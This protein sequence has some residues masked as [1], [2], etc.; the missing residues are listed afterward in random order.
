MIITYSDM[1]TFPTASQQL[2][3]SN[4]LWGVNPVNG[5]PQTLL[6]PDLLG[7][8]SA[9]GNLSLISPAFS[10]WSNVGNITFQQG[11]SQNHITFASWNTNL[12]GTGSGST[13]AVGTPYGE[14]TNYDIFLNLAKGSI[15]TAPNVTNWGVWNLAH[16]IGHTLLGAGH[17]PPLLTTAPTDDMRFSIMN[18][19]YNVDGVPNSN[20]KIPLTP[21]L[22]DI[23]NLQDKFGASTTSN[24]NDSYTFIQQVQLYNTIGTVKLG[25]SGSIINID[26]AKA[27]MTIWDSGGIDTIDTST[28][29]TSNYINLNAGHFSAIGSNTTLTT[30][31]INAGGTSLAEEKADV[32]FNVGIAIGAL[33]ENVVSGSANDFIVGNDVSNTILGGAGNDRI[34]GNGGNDYLYGGNN[35]DVLFTGLGN[36]Y[37]N[38]GLGNDVMDG[39]FVVGGGG[40]DTFFLSGGTNTAPFGR[41]SP[42]L[43]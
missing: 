38:G 14:T 19:P 35:D 30:T 4:T 6:H 24:G 9:Y 22:N 23:T 5:L 3:Y 21:G 16:E 1:T 12:Y 8:L 15:V 31:Q 2:A 18:Y 33:I 37:A 25:T 34:L 41:P 26:P 13:Y 7:T 36:D 39:D 43:M 28:M 27:V 17:P 11:S 40:N 32:K 20:V 42:T 10:M 29:T